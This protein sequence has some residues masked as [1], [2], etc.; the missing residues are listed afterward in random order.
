MEALTIK[1]VYLVKKRAPY[2]QGTQAQAQEASVR[3]ATEGSQHCQVE[4]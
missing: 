3:D 2:H 4:Y 1:M